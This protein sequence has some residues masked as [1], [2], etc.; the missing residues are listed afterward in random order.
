[1]VTTP[2]R[3]RTSSHTHRFAGVVAAMVLAIASLSACGES[4]LAPLPLQITVATNRT[5]AAPGDTVYF[6]A[7]V[8]GGQLL[9]LDADYGDNAVDQF[10]T[11]GA[12]T[13]KITFRHAYAARGTFTTKITV[14]DATLGTASASVEIRVN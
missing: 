1:M 11:S 14:T 8:Q 9:G 10:G 2:Y 12:R 3:T 13:G 5:T 4:T 7:T 6:V